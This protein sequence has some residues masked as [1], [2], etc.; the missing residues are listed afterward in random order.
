MVTRKNRL[1]TTLIHLYGPIIC[2][3]PIPWACS[4][5]ALANML[6]GRGEGS[7]SSPNIAQNTEHIPLTH[8]SVPEHQPPAASLGVAEGKQVLHL[9]CLH[10]VLITP[11]L[12]SNAF[13]R[14]HF[15]KLHTVGKQNCP[16]RIVMKGTD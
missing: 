1:R 14:P 4:K 7:D 13:H 12:L 10:L 3:P 5:S 2:S 11:L 8:I 15:Q 9:A 6:V 16:S